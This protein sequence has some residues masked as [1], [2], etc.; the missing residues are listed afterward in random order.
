MNPRAK[1][2]LVVRPIGVIRTP[3][4]ERAEAPRQPRA[5]EGVEGTIELFSGNDFQDAL[6]DLDS[7]EYVW[8]LFWF[9]RNETWRPKVLPPRSTQRR[10]LFSTRS[11]HRPN[12]IGLS[13]V[14][15][16][17]VVGLSVRVADIDLLDET[18]ILDIKPYVP[19]TDAIVDTR[20]GWL[21]EENATGRGERPGDPLDKFE[22]TFDARARDQL[23]F[24]KTLAV[25]LEERARSVLELG[26]R[27]HAY[28][29]IRLD[30]DDTGTLAIKDWRARFRSTGRRIVV[31]SIASGFR[32]NQLP[33]DVPGRDVHRAFVARF[34]GR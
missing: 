16:I 4:R 10:G 3:F 21:D 28:R 34:G 5:A 31:L 17:S 30:D 25:D 29:R 18:P 7:W 13:V 23:D 32:A 12:P 1:G 2:E 15:L 9:H 11:P 27:P 26:P 14:R 22:V 6:S 24:L 19:W 8:L 33:E 20:A